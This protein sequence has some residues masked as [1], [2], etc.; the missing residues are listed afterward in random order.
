MAA[1]LRQADNSTQPEKKKVAEN[2]AER[3]PAS[4]KD[5]QQG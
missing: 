5:G 4:G 2:A 3:R 1:Y